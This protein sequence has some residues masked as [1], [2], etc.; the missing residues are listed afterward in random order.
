MKGNIMGRP[1]KIT[2]GNRYGRLVV[3]NVEGLGA[4]KH[5]VAICQCDCGN[6]TKVSSHLLKKIKSC[7]CSQY[8]LNFIKKRDADSYNCLPKGEAMMNSYFH[9]Y[10]NAAKKRNLPFTLTK[11]QFID[12][13]SMSCHYC[14][15]EPTYKMLYKKDGRPMHNGGI[16]VNGVDRMNNTDGYSLE[17]SVACCSE[18]NFAKHA[19]SKESFVAHCQRVVDNFK[20]EIENE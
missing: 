9:S 19:R 7:G 6:V 15:A 14:G 5:A 18:C 13:T 12:L 4:G 1:S 3:T 10:V 2:I 17:N 8:D 11:Q 16:V 20:K